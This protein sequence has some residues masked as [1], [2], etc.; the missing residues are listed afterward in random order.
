M[1][2]LQ[3]HKPF[4][5]FFISKNFNYSAEFLLFWT[6]PGE[7]SAVSFMIIAA[8]R[9]LAVALR[10]AQQDKSDTELITFAYNNFYEETHFVT[11][12]K[13]NLIFYCHV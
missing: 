9:L 8:N 12:L 1:K 3:Q 2:T 13:Y 5:I 10:L 4:K 11:W 6:E 7:L